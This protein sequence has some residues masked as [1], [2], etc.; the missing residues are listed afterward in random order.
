MAKYKSNERR[1][2]EGAMTRIFSMD[3]NKAE[4]TDRA[5]RIL[6]GAANALQ[7]IGSKIVKESK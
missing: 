6:E 3:L 7:D 2:I 1:I 4:A 5:L